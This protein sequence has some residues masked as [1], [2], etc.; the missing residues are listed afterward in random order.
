MKQ[1]MPWRAIALTSCLSLS[2]AT[3]P[4][5]ANAQQAPW[6]AKPIRLVVGG[7]AGGNADSLA[8]LLADGMQKQLGKPV[9]V[10]SK[11]GAAGVL[12]VNDL[13]ANGKDAHTFLLIQGG[14]VSETPLAYKVSYQPFKDLKPLAQLSRN[15]LVLIANK[16]FP[17]SNLQQLADYGKKQSDGLDFAS[18]ATGMRGHTSG[19]L[20]GQLLNIKMKHLGYKGS[21]PALSDLMG[22]HVPLMMDGLTTAL[23]LIKAGKVKP[24]AVNYPAR[25]V[26][27]PDVPTFKELGYP[28]LSEVSWFGVWSRPDIPADVQARVREIA[29]QYFKQPQIE[30][31][32]RDMGMES[33]T[34][35]PPEALMSELQKAFQR[36][37]ALLKSIDYQPQ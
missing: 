19:M 37:Q 32:L 18:Y 3:M 12:A 2:A 15:G 10:E 28:Q 6:P 33:G 35:A 27:L 7:P 9:I 14:I 26:Q 1:T 23:P 21:P 11:P 8:R 16:D 20:L 5:T 13:L 24:L 36:Q 25:M 4:L 29:L 30:A 17:A 31:R 22:G 34:D